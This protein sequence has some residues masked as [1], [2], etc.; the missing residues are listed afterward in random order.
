MEGS[1]GQSDESGGLDTTTR[2]AR[3]VVGVVVTIAA[4]ALAIVHIARPHAA[5]DGTTVALLGIAALP[6]L[7]SIFDRIELPGGI[8]A[9]YRRRLNEV[10]QK[11]A[12]VESELARFRGATPELTARLEEA[13][14]QLVCV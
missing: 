11:V 14:R 10:E 7:G 3:V 5:I 6:W 13:L 8:K 4:A 2:A 1:P 12:V 9:E